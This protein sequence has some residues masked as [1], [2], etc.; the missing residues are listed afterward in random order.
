MSLNDTQIYRSQTRKTH[1]ALNININVNFVLEHNIS[2][3]NK[4]HSGASW[5]PICWIIE[6]DSE[7]T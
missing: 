5:T 3:P 2:K 4:T 6:I 7:E 1:Q